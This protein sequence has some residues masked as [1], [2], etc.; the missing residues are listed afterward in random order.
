M[1]RFCR[2]ICLVEEVVLLVDLEVKVPAEVVGVVVE[3]APAEA[4]VVPEVEVALEHPTKEIVC[5]S[6]I[7]VSIHAFSYYDYFVDFM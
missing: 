7:L 2:T 1:Y 6:V 3:A 5:I 4:E